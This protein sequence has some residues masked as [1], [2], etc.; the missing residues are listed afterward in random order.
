MWARAHRWLALGLV[1]P[2][3]VWSVTG[4]VFHLKPGWARA[5]DQ[6]DEARPGPLD[7]AAVTAIAS[8]PGPATGWTASRV[9]LFD[10]A[11]GPLYR[12]TILDGSALYDARTG[13]R[14]SPL[15]VADARSLAV[16]AVARSE[17]HAAYGDPVEVREAPAEFRIQFS[18]GAVV[19]I[20]RDDG[21]LTQRGADTERIDWLYRLHYLQWT[22]N[23]AID[24]VIAGAGLG[25]IWL[26][27][28]PGLVL[29]ARRLRRR[30]DRK[31]S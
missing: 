27:A 26:A 21:R 15:A 31:T 20:G 16:D 28:V 22:G 11:L 4:L 24:R 18:G 12:V 7:L 8:L 23:R 25:L 9:E 2:L 5:Y 1:I 29:A 3:L 13:A 10:S 6:L 14:R 17:H 30:A 19:R